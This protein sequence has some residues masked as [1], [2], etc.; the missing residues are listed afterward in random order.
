MVREAEGY[1]SHFDNS[2]YKF[3]QKSNNLIVSSSKNLN[4]EIINK[5]KEWK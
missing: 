5:I 2:S 3:N 4:I 1:D